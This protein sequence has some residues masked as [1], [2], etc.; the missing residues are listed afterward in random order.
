MKSV[1]TVLL[2]LGLAGSSGARDV[3]FKQS[4]DLA[5]QHA[6]TLKKSAAALQSA[7]S[8]LSAAR[9]ERWPTLS[10]TGT[11]YTI[12]DVPTAQLSPGVI[13]ELGT[14]QTYQ[15]DFRLTVP[16]YTGEKI[17]SGIDL[18]RASRELQS[19][20][21]K[22]DSDRIAYTTWTEYLSLQRA[23]RMVEVAQASLKRAEVIAQNVSSLFSA[24]SADS[25]DLNESQLTLARAQLGVTQAVNQRRSAE[26]RLAIVIGASLS[27]PLILTTAAPDPDTSAVAGSPQID[28]SKSEL[29]AAQ[30]NVAA[31]QARLRL[32]LSEF[33]PS[34]SAYGG[35]SAGKPNQNFLAN[36]WRD[37]WQVGA[38]LNWSFNLGGRGTSKRK[39]ARFD[40]ISS[41]SEQDRVTEQL[42][43]DAQLSEVQ[44]RLAYDKYESAKTEYRIAGDQYRLAQQRHQN[45]DLSSNRLTD[46]EAS[47]TAAQSSMAASLADYWLS[48]AAF[49]YAIGSPRLQEGF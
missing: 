3:S 16:I 7:S 44:V 5:Q 21:A 37:F 32:S 27:D 2:V 11:A 18:A 10:F 34:L 35:Y 9:A 1:T 48:L 36:K 30:A 6:Y 12:D 41:K 22:G 25:V 28:S 15:T 38:N 49:Y 26:I 29:R 20:L 47:L 39:A 19:S 45:G 43:R 17:S 40:L 13:R 8:S 31:N 42:G 4:L 33:L 14:K 46:I 24:G 23:D